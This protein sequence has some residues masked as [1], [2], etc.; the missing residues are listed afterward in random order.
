MSYSW[1]AAELQLCS[2][3]FHSKVHAFSL[4]SLANRLKHVGEEKGLFDSLTFSRVVRAEAI[5]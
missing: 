4:F 5:F 1:Q 3:L 2:D